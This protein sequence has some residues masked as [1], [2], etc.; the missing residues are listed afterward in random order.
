MFLKVIVLNSI[1]IKLVENLLGLLPWRVTERTKQLNESN[2]G[3][4]KF[5]SSLVLLPKKH[6]NS[7]DFFFSLV[8]LDRLNVST[9]HWLVIV[10]KFS[11]F[12]AF[13]TFHQ[14]AARRRRR[15]RRRRFRKVWW[16]RP[17]IGSAEVV[18]SPIQPQISEEFRDQF[19]ISWCHFV[20][21]FCAQENKS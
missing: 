7:N 6:Q 14:R 1:L 8:T 12:R 21:D 13:S 16:Y 17:G 18:R 5:P 19:C 15:R 3:M 2:S 9:Q 11:Q 10:N 4:K 20:A